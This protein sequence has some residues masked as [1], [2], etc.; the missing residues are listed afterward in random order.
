M[1]NPARRGRRR[2]LRGNGSGNVRR[3]L[4]MENHLIENGKRFNPSPHPPDFC[5]IPWFNLIVRVEDFTSISFGITGVSGV[6]SLVEQLRSQLQLSAND[7]LEYRVQSVRIWGALVAMN[8]GSVLPHLRARFWSLVPQLASASGSSA[9][10]VLEDISA[11]PDQV[12]RATIGFIYPRSQQ[13]IPIQFGNAGTLVS[14]VA[15][16]GANV[17]AYVK[18]CW[19]PRQTLGV[20]ETEYVIP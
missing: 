8:S 3:L 6:V 10:T 5:A 20:L 16:G 1:V 18:L 17:I 2:A 7:V 14:L 19:R 12:S 9:F 13:A 15:G 4:K 11:Y